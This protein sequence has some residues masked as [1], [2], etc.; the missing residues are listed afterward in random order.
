MKKIIFAVVILWFFDS[1]MAQEIY[2]CHVN[3]NVV[4]QGKACKG[5]T[6]NFKKHLNTGKDNDGFINFNT[7]ELTITRE[8]PSDAWTATVLPTHP[9][10]AKCTKSYTKCWDINNLEYLKIDK[11]TYRQVKRPNRECDF[12]GGR[13]WC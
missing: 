8:E 2:R 4:F 1:A 3:G 12:R 10:V 5:Q 11:N 9:L 13:M 7:E 6:V